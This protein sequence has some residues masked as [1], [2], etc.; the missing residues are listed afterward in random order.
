MRR[1]QRPTPTPPAPCCAEQLEDRRLLS[2]G[3]VVAYLP[4]YRFGLFNSIDLG[5]ITHLNYFSI[6]ANADG[7]LTTVKTFPPPTPPY[8]YVDTGHLDT[9]VTAA[10][11]R[12]VTVSIV[13][14]PG[15]AFTSFDAVP[16][17]TTAFVNNIKA[18]CT[19]HALDGI[20]L[21]WEP[22]WGSATVVQINNYGNLI[23][24][25]RAA[26]PNLLLS[27]AVN[28][29][30]LVLSD[31]NPDQYIIKPA[32]MSKLDWIAPM[33]YELNPADHSPEGPWES[34]MAGWGN[35]LAANGVS[36]TRIVAGVPFYGKA[37]TGW[38]DAQAKTYGELIDGYRAANGVFPAAN[39]DSVNLTYIGLFNSQPM[40]WYFN[41]PTT[42]QTKSQYVVNNGLGGVMIW[43]LGQDHFTGGAYDTHS[44][45]PVIKS[46][47]NPPFA[48]LSGGVVTV[49]GDNTAEAF[50][51]STVGTNLIIKRNGVPQSFSLASV[52]SIVINGTGGDDTLDFNG[53]ISKGITFNGGTGNDTLRVNSGTFA[54][55]AD[56]QGGNANLSV[57]VNS[58]GSVTFNSATQH[59]ANLTLNSG[60]AA[61]IS[62]NG[63]RTLVTKGLTIAGGRL[64]VANNTLILD[65]G[66]ANP[67]V[68]VR[69]WL[70]SGRNGGAWNG[71]NGIMSSSVP[72]TP[73]TGLGYSQASQL[74]SSFPA[75]FAGESIDN[76]ALLVRYT[77]DGDAN[78]NRTV[79][80]DDLNV[81][82]MNWQAS[83]RVF[84]TGD[85]NY[86]GIVNE[87]DLG[88]IS[89]NWQK[90]MASGGGGLGEI[91]DLPAAP[92]EQVPGRKSI[93][94]R[95]PVRE[96]ILS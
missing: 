2:G 26:A 71:T 42:I 73:Y 10:H 74:F 16:A 95:Q 37:G 93:S 29:L 25:L 48:A 13:V 65:Y 32:Q 60:G 14:D 39:V 90:T 53:P 75:T 87:I 4:E 70:I 30:K 55:S 54:F 23:D 21:D 83:P 80:V 33:G 47:I 66:G 72:G 67:E 36:K 24:Q 96:L 91:E 68:D 64:D 41:G 1:H 76:T 28:P 40:T 17:A 34:A 81:V 11:A 20:D 59:L 77:F 31:G 94:N 43:E 63:A 18:F 88:S 35:Y 22:A 19:A 12:G 61:T 78:L 89:L 86:D 38:G 3:R 52:S 82:A 84:S 50:T 79:D 8:T 15:S 9:A 49:S 27:A 56:A 57:I 44:L 5:S 45:L 46:V 51:L 6:L 7:S 85:F 62:A 58:G 69:N 92:V